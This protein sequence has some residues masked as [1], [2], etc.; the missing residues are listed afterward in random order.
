MKEYNY[1]VEDQKYDRKFEEIYRRIWVTGGI[2]HLYPEK[3]GS[4]SEHIALFPEFD[5]IFLFGDMWDWVINDVHEVGSFFRCSFSDLHY[6]SEKICCTSANRHQRYIYKGGVDRKMFLEKAKEWLDEKMQEK[7]ENPEDVENNVDDIMFD[8]QD[9]DTSD[10]QHT[11]EETKRIMDSHDVD[12]FYEEI[13]DLIEDATEWDDLYLYICNL[14]RWFWC[15]H[16][17]K[18]EEAMR[19][20][21]ER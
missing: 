14:L 11:Y 7:Y 6:W 3:G 10:D 12:Y 8:L 20:I 9:V 19:Q 15:N 5:R 16:R 13:G 2:I 1:K 18:I 21:E 4:R 17:D